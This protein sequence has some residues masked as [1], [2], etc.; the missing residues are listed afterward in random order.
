MLLLPSRYGLQPPDEARVDGAT[1]LSNFLSSVYVPGQDGMAGID[2]KGTALLLANGTPTRSWRSQGRF[3]SDNGA[4]YIGGGIANI[5]AFPLVL[6]AAGYF[7]SGANNW[8]LCSLNTTGGGG[9]S[10]CE[11][12][13]T[14]STEID[15]I[16]RNNFGTTATVAGT[17]LSGVTSGA[18]Y[19]CVAQSLSATDHRL[20]IKG[21]QYT[22]STNMG[23]ITSA[24]NGF[25][26]GGQGTGGTPV[27]KLNGGVLFAAYGR[28]ALPDSLASDVSRDPSVFWKMFPRKDQTMWFAAG[29]ANFLM[30]QACL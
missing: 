8:V 21:T 23:G 6:I 14:S 22:S 27:A 16:I 2:R 13:L 10:R 5:S 11:I 20:Y 25:L 1:P 12:V 7:A 4:G 9:S 18:F 3:Y 24:Y 15:Y 26:I 30:G 19:V 29:A 17:G 28:R